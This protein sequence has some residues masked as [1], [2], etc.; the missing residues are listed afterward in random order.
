MLLLAKVKFVLIVTF[1][2]LYHCPQFLNRNLFIR[3]CFNRIVYEYIYLAVPFLD[4]VD[5]AIH[6]L[7]CFSPPL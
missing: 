1:C 2:N 5:L 3:L 6:L 4:S 7:S